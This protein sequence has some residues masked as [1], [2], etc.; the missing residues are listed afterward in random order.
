MPVDLYVGGGEHAVLHL[1]YARFW[2]K[3]LFD[4][5]LVHTKEP[6]KKLRHQGTVLA[7]STRTALGRYHEPSEIEFRGETAVLK[8]TGET[9][10]SHRRE[11][12]EVEAERRQPRRRHPRLRR[13]RDAPLRDVHGRV[14]AAEALG[15]A[16]HRGRAPLPRIASGA[17][18]RSGTVRDAPGDDPH[19]RLR[20]KTI[21][22]VTDDI[23]RMQFNTAIAGDD[24]V[25]EHADRRGGAAHAATWSTLVKLVG[26]FAPHLGDEAWERLG[27]TGFLL[28]AP[29]PTYDEALTIDDRVTVG[30]QVDG[31]L[32]G[33]VEIARDATEDDARTA[34]LAIPNVTKHLEG[35]TIKKF[36]YKPGRI[37]GIV[38][39]PA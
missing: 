11:D 27:G 23:E 25:R 38:T 26:P 30:V 24:G 1:L 5:G 14:R 31:K 19:E 4:M 37:I 28:Q 2:H 16:R 17:C 10:T 6:F 15:P 9:L 13:R 32:R 21:K 22:K 3:V 20:H 8:A 7:Y 33:D 36:I 39:G 12:G 29:W 34:A 35:R 18:A